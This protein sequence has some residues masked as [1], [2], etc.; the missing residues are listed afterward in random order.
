MKTL[1]TIDH[2]IL[3]LLQQNA[4]YTNKEIASR[5]GMTTTPVYER[6]KKLEEGGYIRKYV[7]LVDREKLDY[8]LVAYCNVSLKEHAQNYLNQFEQQVLA[9]AEVQECYHIAGA[10]DYL[11]KV[12]IRDIPAYQDFI[13]NKLAALDNIGNVQS[14]F[15]MTEV[16]FST[17][18]VNGK[19]GTV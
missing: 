9:L 6:I 1:D 19:N 17:A 14:S 7:A 2:H 4:K 8:A 10:F 3:D 18:V 15:V 16:K 13:V 11:L 12:V 5:L